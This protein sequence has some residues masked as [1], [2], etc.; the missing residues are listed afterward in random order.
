MGKNDQGNS[1]ILIEFDLSLNEICGKRDRQDNDEHRCSS[2]FDRTMPNDI[3]EQLIQ[4]IMKTFTY[5]SRQA[6]HLL[7]D[8]MM[9]VKRRDLV[10]PFFLLD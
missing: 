7:K 8:L 3:Q 4:T 1:K 2:S 6:R 5:T 9:C 10:R